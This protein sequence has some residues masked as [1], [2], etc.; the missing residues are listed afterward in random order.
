VLRSLAPLVA[1]VL[2]L[3]CGADPLPGYRAA[4]ADERASV[5]AVIAEYFDLL[6]SAVVSGDIGPLRARHPLLAQ[7]TDAQ[8]GINS[9][10]VTLQLP[11]VRDHLIREARVDPQAYEPVRVYLQGD[12]AVAYVHG[13]Y[14]WDRVTGAPTQGELRVRFDLSR[15]AD[16]WTIE[17]TDEV[18]L[19]ETPPPTPR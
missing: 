9:E 7:G 6:D 5:L 16:R 15:A 18:V 10:A 11:S 13:W 8:R 14:T 19:G 12:R 3:A 4:T 2:V 17:R 1:A